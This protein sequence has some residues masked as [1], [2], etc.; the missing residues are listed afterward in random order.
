MALYFLEGRDVVLCED[1]WRT[2]LSAAIA[3][4]PRLMRLR[5]EHDERMKQ[6]RELERQL[7]DN[8]E[9]SLKQRIDELYRYDLACLREASSIEDSVFLQSAKRFE[10]YAALLSY[11]SSLQR[12]RAERAQA[13]R[14]RMSQKLKNDV[15]NKANSSLGSTK[16]AL[17]QVHEIEV[18]L[19]RFKQIV[20]PVLRLG[21]YE[22][23]VY[24]TNYNTE[25]SDYEAETFGTG[26][27]QKTRDSALSCLQRADSILKSLS[28][29]KQNLLRIRERI[30]NIIKS[31]NTASPSFLETLSNQLS[32]IDSERSEIM[33]VHSDAQSIITVVHSY[34]Q[35]VLN[36][37]NCLHSFR[38]SGGFI[39]NL[40]QKI[41]WESA[42]SAAKTKN[43]SLFEAVR[44][45][46]AELSAYFKSKNKNQFTGKG[47]Y[48][49]EIY[50]IRSF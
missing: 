32:D 40:G 18:D 39:L 19:K 14:E 17:E 22:T 29:C 34:F 46:N 26:G 3:N 21:V 5:R 33:A 50:G 48:W 4:R 24:Y 28:Q 20:S 36:L 44:K 47:L 1:C 23:S 9:Y 13:E 12:I 42:K 2:K 45:A 30:E 38:D 25:D 37:P 7:E 35:R 27:L 15:L 31:A 43:V 49:Q 41:K 11:Y 6:T 16:W 10:S 8:Y